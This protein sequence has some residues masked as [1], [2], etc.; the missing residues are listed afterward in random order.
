MN[1]GIWRIYFSISDTVSIQ[2]D[3][4]AASTPGNQQN[5]A[6]VTSKW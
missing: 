4:H 1:F 5:S 3:V 2:V 6:P